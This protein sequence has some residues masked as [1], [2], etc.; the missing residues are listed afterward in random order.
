[1]SHTF[2]RRMALSATAA[3]LVATNFLSSGAADAAA[4]SADRQTAATTGHYAMPTPK[5]VLVAEIMAT[6]AAP[7]EVGDGIS[8]ARRMISITGGTV[9]GPRLNGKILPGGADFQLIRHDDLAEIEAQYIVETP[10]GARVYIENKGLRR[11]PAE[12]S[13]RLKRGE[14]VDPA[15][16]Y[17][18]T[19]PRF[20]TAAAE[21]AWMERSIF[22]SAGARFPD[23]VQFS[24]YEVA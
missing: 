11:A 9:T 14:P 16:V 8:G 17:F 19:T 21:F 1:M 7:V 20:E 10:T 23:Y 4:D 6:L 18:R 2:S 13:A 24:V 22:V 5:L 15:L 3:S 12:I